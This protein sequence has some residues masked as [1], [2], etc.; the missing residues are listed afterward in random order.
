MQ[1]STHCV[2]V[3]LPSRRAVKG[4]LGAPRAHARGSLDGASFSDGYH[5]CSH[6]MSDIAQLTSEFVAY[7]WRTTCVASAL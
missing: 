7:F 3:A 1:L 6:V 5:C 2:T 4:A